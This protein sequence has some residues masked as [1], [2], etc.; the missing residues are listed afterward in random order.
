MNVGAGAG[1]YEPPRRRVIA[2]EPSALMA[3]QRPPDRGPSVRGV[4]DALPFHD[5]AVDAAMTVLSM[6][7]WH[8][9]QKR[10][11]QEM[12]RVARDR[13]VIVTI[14]PRVSGRMW[15]MADYFPEVAALDT[16]TFPCPDAIVRWMDRPARVEVVPVP[17]D[18]PDG[19]LLSF[20]AHPERVLDPGA[21][22]A[23]SGFARQ[24]AAV[25]DRVVSAVAQDLK[26]GLW[27]A[28]YGALRGLDAID[29]GL[30]LIC[31]RPSLG[32]ERGGN[33]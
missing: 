9:R 11:V 14:D 15:L 32:R 24:P 31:A 29:V 8:P 7:H 21:R 26:T 5:G 1:S 10:G 16:A 27:D 18:T 22:A 3:A 33:G 28:R 12:C 6:H 17:R 2:V 13:V 4:A 23:T 25:V 30:R 19:M 20:W